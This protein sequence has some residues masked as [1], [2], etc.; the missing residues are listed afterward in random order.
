[1]KNALDFYAPCVHQ[2]YVY[3]MFGSFSS[4]KIPTNIKIKV[5]FVEISDTK[6]ENDRKNDIK[7]LV[8]RCKQALEIYIKDDTEM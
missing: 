5:G 2:I 7:P 6:G 3:V 8:A 4:S 1:M